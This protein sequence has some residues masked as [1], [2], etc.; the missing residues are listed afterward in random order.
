MGFSNLAISAVT[1]PPLTT[2]QVGAREI[3][4]CA[5]QMILKRINNEPILQTPVDT[6]FSIVERESA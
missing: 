5:A 1:V 6:G 2:V 4:I 3:G